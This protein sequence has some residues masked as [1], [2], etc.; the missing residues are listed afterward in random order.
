[1]TAKFP[2]KQPSLK[3]KFPNIPMSDPNMSDPNNTTTLPAAFATSAALAT[4]AAFATLAA[5][6]LFASPVSASAS[7]TPHSVPHTP[8]SH[9]ALHTLP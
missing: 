8:P 7:H 9:S 5:P 3:A 1:M 6:C 4:F 2:Q